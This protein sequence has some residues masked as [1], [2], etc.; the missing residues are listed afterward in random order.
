MQSSQMD[1]ILTA[2]AIEMRDL[3]RRISD[4]DMSVNGN[5]AG[6]SYMKQAGYSDVVA[7]SNPNNPGGITDAAWALQVLSF[8]NTPS[9]VYFGLLQQGGTGG[10]GA[11]IQNFN[12]QLAGVWGG[13]VV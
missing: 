7:T 11:T 1:N 4:L 6:L 9:R 10:T 13:R 5:G 12:L 2:L 3:M 8:L